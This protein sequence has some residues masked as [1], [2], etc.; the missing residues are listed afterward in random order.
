LANVILKIF[1]INFLI[2]KSRFYAR[3][4][5]VERWFFVKNLW[6]DFDKNL[7][8]LQSKMKHSILKLH[9]IT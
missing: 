8:S 4:F 7:V 2:V 9:V 6:I 3:F 1:P 5:L